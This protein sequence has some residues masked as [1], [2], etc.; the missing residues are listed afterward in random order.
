MFF[1]R[2]A[3]RKRFR[4]ELFRFPYEDE[5]KKKMTTFFF[6][7]RKKVRRLP[8]NKHKNKQRETAAL[9][10]EGKIIENQSNDNKITKTISFSLFFSSLDFNDSL[11]QIQGPIVTRFMTK[12]EKKTQKILKFMDILFQNLR[13]EKFHRLLPMVRI[14]IRIKKVP[15]NHQRRAKM[16]KIYVPPRFPFVF[17]LIPLDVNHLCSEIVKKCE[18]NEGRVDS[19]EKR[20]ENESKKKTEQSVIFFS[21]RFLYLEK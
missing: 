15:T 20:T 14:S 2:S 12:L 3:S 7:S 10:I 17:I 1:S 11:D 5:K 4:R 13:L 21:F 9:S 19:K 16:V 8:D 18:P 6:A